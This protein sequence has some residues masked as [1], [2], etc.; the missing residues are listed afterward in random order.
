MC[1]KIH[2]GM[3]AQITL[4][5]LVCTHVSVHGG[6][7]SREVVRCA[8]GVPTMFTHKVMAM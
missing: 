1:F 5:T 2:F 8:C 7:V 3:T 4:V 6:K